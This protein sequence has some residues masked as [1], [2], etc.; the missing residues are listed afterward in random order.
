MSSLR[1]FI[2]ILISCC[3]FST[4]CQ[5]AEIDTITPYSKAL[6]DITD[7][8]NEIINR[9][10]REGV[11]NANAHRDDF[12]LF[13]ERGMCDEEILYTEL[14]KA[15]FH[16][17]SA[18]LGLK[19]YSLDKQLRELLASQSY[20]LPLE[21]SIYRDITFLEGISLN[22]KELSNV[23]RIRDQLIGLDKI[24]HFFAEGWNYFEQTQEDN[25]TIETAIAWGTELEEGTFGYLTTGIFSYADLVANFNGFRFWNGLRKKTKDPIE[26]VIAD[27]FTSQQISCNFDLF[28]SIKKRKIVRKW[29]LGKKFDISE[30]VD[31][32][33]NEANNCNRYKDTA[34]EAKVTARIAEV[35]PGF[36]C[37]EDRTV[38]MKASKKYDG[39]AK[40]LLHPQCLIASHDN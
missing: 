24:G 16:S 28:A 6:P 34:I 22:L 17:F 4:V 9:R 12:T 18:S 3:S 26:T 8:L 14:R 23:V 13:S 30:Y 11:D 27:F 15:I 29:V 40:Y 2:C 31:G 19:G 32:S 1:I 21:D 5:T 37:P 38:C 10:L 33:W 25:A 36:L 20:S 7:T 39:Y 35:R